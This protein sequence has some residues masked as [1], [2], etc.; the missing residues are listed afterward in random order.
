LLESPLGFLVSVRNL[1]L[2]DKGLYILCLMI[3]YMAIDWFQ[4]HYG[5]PA[6][7]DRLIIHRAMLGVKAMPP[8]GSA[9]GYIFLC[10]IRVLIVLFDELHEALNH[11]IRAASTSG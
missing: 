4:T 8:P 10:F 11:C 7:G 5:V 3:I 1:I 2:V 6:A 9:A